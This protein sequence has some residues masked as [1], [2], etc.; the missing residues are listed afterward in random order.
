MIRARQNVRNGQRRQNGAFT[1]IELLVVI[2]IVAV[3]VSILLP[4][5]TMG[6]EAANVAFC[7]ANLRTLAQT[8]GDY[9]VD[10]DPSGTGSNPTQPWYLDTTAYAGVAYVSEYV[11]GGYRHTT[12]NP[13]FPQSDT[14][15]IPTE[16]RPY[17]KYVAPGQSGRSPI[18]QYVCPSDKS[19]ATPLARPIREDPDEV[20]VE[21]R[22]SSWEIHGNSYAIN[23]Y[24]MQGTP[25]PDY[26]LSKM[27]ALGSAMLAKKVGG[28]AAEFVIFSEAMMNAYMYEARPPDGLHGTSRLQQLGLGWHRKRSTYSMGFYDG[29]AEYR[30]LDT[31]YSSGPGYNTWPQPATAWPAM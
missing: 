16:A 22:Y 12:E 20:T 6:R 29:H 28:A 7:E 9:V 30:Y 1:L 26:Q 4:A 21:E 31:R 8:S 17:N 23:W 24:W 15:I 5:L 11:Y 25:H 19:A 10:N 2:S 3:L 13:H 18:K 14:Y 27:H